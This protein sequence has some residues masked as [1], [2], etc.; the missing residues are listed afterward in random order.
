MYVTEGAVDLLPP[1]RLGWVD[2]MDSLS[3]DLVD[4]TFPYACLGSMPSRLLLGALWPFALTSGLAIAIAVHALVMQIAA[5]AA[6]PSRGEALRTYA[7]RCL[8]ALVVVCH[9]VLPSVSR[10]IFTAQQCTAYAYDDATGQTISF[11]TADLSMHCNAG[12]GWTDEA[13]S[14]AAYFW[15]FFVLWPVLVPLGFLALLLRVRAAL[16]AQRVTS[17]AR[18]SAFLWR[19]Y[20]SA[21]LYWEC[22]DLWRKVCRAT[23][24]SL[25]LPSS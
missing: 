24:P 5:G 22:V 8:Y 17:I 6:A 10:S 11:L 14:L 7:S 1:A 4:L 13:H 12:P 23:P 21:H 19:D 2:F 15:S 18:S 25:P 16:R 3:L 9:L 20:E